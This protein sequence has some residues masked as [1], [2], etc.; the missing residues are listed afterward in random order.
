MKEKTVSLLFEKYALSSIASAKKF[1]LDLHPSLINIKVILHLFIYFFLFGRED[2][3]NSLNFF[4][5]LNYANSKTCSKKKKKRKKLVTVNLLLLFCIKLGMYIILSELH[6]Y[7]N[8]LYES[9][10]FT[11]ELFIF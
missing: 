9:T 11:I 7:F 8:I 2:S 3:S 1:E 5:I 10:Q 4:L 6:T